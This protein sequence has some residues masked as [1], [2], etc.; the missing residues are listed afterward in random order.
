MSDGMSDGDAV[1]RL[2]QNVWNAAYD[3]RKAIKAAERGHRGLV[4][5]GMVETINEQLEQV[6]YQLV[7]KMDH[8]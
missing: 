2:H 1:G 7:R 6:G 8:R 3:L 4:P 5:A